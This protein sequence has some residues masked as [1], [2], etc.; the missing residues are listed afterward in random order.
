[1]MCIKVEQRGIELFPLEFHQSIVLV[2]KV[3]IAIH[4]VTHEK[5]V[6][7]S[8]GAILLSSFSQKPPVS[9]FINSVRSFL[10]SHVNVK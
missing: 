1:M 3:G 2:L 7:Q 8:I 6:K 5:T 4:D 9:F 10:L